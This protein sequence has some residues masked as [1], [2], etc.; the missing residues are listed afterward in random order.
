[1][2]V[3]CGVHTI[4]YGSRAY[5]STDRPELARITVHATLAVRHQ[6]LA[7]GPLRGH[8]RTCFQRQGK[9]M[10]VALL[11]LQANKTHSAASDP[12]AGRPSPTGAVS[13]SSVGAELAHATPIVC[14]RT[15]QSAALC[16]ADGS[17]R[18]VC[19]LAHGLMVKSMLKLLP[20]ATLELGT[21]S[22]PSRC[23]P[24]ALLPPRAEATGALRE[25]T[26]PAS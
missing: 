10:A 17:R 2:H 22:M 8:L 23:R 25:L 21:R 9:H 26:A 7:A 3:V 24:P 20:P 19:A 12:A 5:R 4:D 6:G 18:S 14:A 16:E 15:M 1:M 11:P 13:I